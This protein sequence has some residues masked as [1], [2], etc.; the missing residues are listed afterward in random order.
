M[1][2]V[3]VDDITIKETTY[4]ILK[5]DSKGLIVLFSDEN[6]GVVVRPDKGTVVRPDAEGGMQIGYSSSNWCEANFVPFNG[7]IMLY[8]L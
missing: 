4:P 8:N 1:I 7:T 5:K 6:K 3:E 2:T